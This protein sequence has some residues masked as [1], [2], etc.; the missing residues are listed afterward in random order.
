MKRLFVV[1]CLA[2]I[3][4]FF[5]N[6]SIKCPTPSIVLKGGLITGGPTRTPPVEAYQNTTS[7]DLVFNVD[8]GDLTIDVINETG[9]SVFQTV[10]KTKAGTTLTID[11]SGWEAGEYILVIMDGQGGYLEGSFL[12]D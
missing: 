3:S 9:D 11:T 1:I 12:I 7:V 8:L 4:S 6:A 5:T 10:V 2:C